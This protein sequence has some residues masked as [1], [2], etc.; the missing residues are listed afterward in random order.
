MTW[1]TEVGSY[2]APQHIKLDVM[3]LCSGS[4]G[5]PLQELSRQRWHPL[6]AKDLFVIAWNRSLDP[7]L[8][9]SRSETYVRKG[10]VDVTKVHLTVC[11]PFDGRYTKDP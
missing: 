2:I 10:L 7:R 1:H 3:V 8:I 4:E 6:L 5:P 11:I 9:A